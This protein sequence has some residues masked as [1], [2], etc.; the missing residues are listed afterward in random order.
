MSN[1]LQERIY[2]EWF[3]KKKGIESQ[4]VEEADPPDFYLMLQNKRIGVELTNIFNEPNPGRKGSK[5]KRQESHRIQWLQKLSLDY[6]RK[7][8]IPISVKIFL[9]CSEESQKDISGDVLDAL[10]KSK[11][12][13]T[14][15]SKVQDLDCDRRTIEV[16]VQR[17]PSIAIFKN[18]SEWTCINDHMGESAPVSKAHIIHA[19]K[20]EKKLNTYRLNCDQVWLLVVIDRSWKS[21]Q[22]YFDGNALQIKE[23]SFDSVWLLEYP[24]KIHELFC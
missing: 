20:K 10:L 19:L 2:L 5:S 24:I 8:E 13:Y 15:E 12:L 16:W 22:L 1:K 18:C 9:P 17:L 3:L 23:T 11:E 4:S 7:C 14:W 6:Y 21:G